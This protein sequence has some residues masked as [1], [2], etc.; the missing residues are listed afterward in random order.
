MVEERESEAR[1]VV[2]FVALLFFFSLSLPPL[3]ALAALLWPCLSSTFFFSLSLGLVAQTPREGRG[4]RTEKEEPAASK[5]SSKAV[6][7]GPWGRDAEAKGGRKQGAHV[8]V[9]SSGGVDCYK[10]F[11][12]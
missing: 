5:R 3:L 9:D 6:A 2:L 7:R 11:H 10:R 1:L 8:A 4:G 12:M